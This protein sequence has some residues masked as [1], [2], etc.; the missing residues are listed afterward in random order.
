MNVAISDIPIRLGYQ[1]VIMVSNDDR[2]TD[3]QVTY[4]VEGINLDQRSYIMGL[5]GLTTV[6]WTKVE[7]NAASDLFVVSV[8]QDQ[9]FVLTDQLDLWHLTYRLIENKDWTMDTGG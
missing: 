8:P 5:I 3:M 9:I 4:E 1:W 6:E 2:E 7:S